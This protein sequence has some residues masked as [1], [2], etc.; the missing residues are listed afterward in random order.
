MPR[1][2]TPKPRNMRGLPRASMDLSQID[3][4]RKGE[5]QSSRESAMDAARPRT[6]WMAQV[7]GACSGR[8]GR[9]PAG[10]QSWRLC[11]AAG[12]GRGRFS[13][14][15]SVSASNAWLGAAAIVA[16]AIAG[17]TWLAPPRIDEG[18][19][20]FLPSPALERGLPADVYR[21]LEDEFDKAISARRCAARRR[22]LAAGKA[23][24][25]IGIARSSL[26]VFTPTAFFTSR[27]CRAR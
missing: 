13:A 16:V 24:A 9:R 4:L 20:V 8:R 12:H 7:R 14:A 19:N 26:C 3:M 22:P 11:A 17:Q 5:S 6:N 15:R 27:R 2:I 25:K 18:H 10:Q 23:P 21:H 1:R